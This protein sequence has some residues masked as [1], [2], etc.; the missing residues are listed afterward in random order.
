MAKFAFRSAALRDHA[1]RRLRLR[2]AELDWKG[3]GRTP[4]RLR[5]VGKGEDVVVEMSRPEAY[6]FSEWLDQTVTEEPAA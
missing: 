6:A 2:A 4:L 1:G 5:L 3:A